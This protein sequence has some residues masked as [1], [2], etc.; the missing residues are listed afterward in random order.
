MVSVM[1]V[2]VMPMMVM[3]VVHI[4]GDIYEALRA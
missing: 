2:M 1:S 4:V 3:A